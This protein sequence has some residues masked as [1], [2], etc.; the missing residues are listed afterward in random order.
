MTNPLA[1]PAQIAIEDRALRL[2]AR[3]ELQRV[4]GI[5]T[6]LWQQVAG[7]PNRDQAD[8]FANMI[9]EYMFHHAFRAA[10]GDAN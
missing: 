4:R 3:P 9:D 6:M 5:V 7:W 1:T 8:R 10:N 2:L